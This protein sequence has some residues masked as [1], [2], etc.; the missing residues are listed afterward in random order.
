MRGNVDW[1]RPTSGID[2]LIEQIVVIKTNIPIALRKK[3]TQ[4]S[5]NKP[6]Y[7]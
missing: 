4:F 5:A 3:Q 2:V 1:Q 6:I 7:R